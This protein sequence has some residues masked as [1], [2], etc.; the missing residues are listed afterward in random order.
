MENNLFGKLGKGWDN[1]NRNTNR[2][3][4]TLTEQP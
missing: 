1:T 2:G 4:T 3:G